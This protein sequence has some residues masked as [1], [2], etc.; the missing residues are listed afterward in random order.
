MPVGDRQMLADRGFVYIRDEATSGL[1]P[2]WYQAAF[3]L[4]SYVEANFSRY[5]DIIGFVARGLAEHQDVV[6]LQRRRERS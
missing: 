5:F 2:D 4:R 6:V 1:F 3:H